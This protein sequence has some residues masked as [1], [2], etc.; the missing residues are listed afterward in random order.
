[1]ARNKVDICIFCEEAPC[2]CN[3]SKK[4]VVKKRVKVREPEA[5]DAKLDTLDKTDISPARDLEAK[6]KLFAKAMKAKA[7]EAPPP[8]PP[9]PPKQTYT[10]RAVNK[11]Q[12]MFEAAVR[13][14]GPLLA[15]DERAKYRAI[16]T[17]EPTMEEKKLVWKERRNAS[18]DEES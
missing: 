17:T 8:P 6:K 1:M 11:E 5:S 18:F 3:T 12:A 10:H 16:L 15:P 4:P 14:L 7:A 13:A 9:A 2:A